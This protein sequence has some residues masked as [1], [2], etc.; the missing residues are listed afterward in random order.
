MVVI[1]VPF[2]KAPKEEIGAVEFA[3]ML[4]TELQKKDTDVKML[5]G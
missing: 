1:T 2:A 5:L 3:S 4:S